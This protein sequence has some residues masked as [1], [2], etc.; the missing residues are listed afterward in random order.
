MNEHYAKLH[1]FLKK[2]L[3]DVQAYL[4]PVEHQDIDDFI[5]AKEFG[6]AF[7]AMIALIVEEKIHVGGELYTALESAAILMEMETEMAKIKKG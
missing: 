7:E 4:E 3:V 6:I 2:A 1:F 5:E